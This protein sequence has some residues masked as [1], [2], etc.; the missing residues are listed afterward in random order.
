[1]DV[2]LLAQHFFAAASTAQQRPG[3]VLPPPV[4]AE[5]GR[6]PWPGN[7]RQLRNEMQ[8]LCALAGS[9]EI[10]VR[11]LSPVE[12]LPAAAS[13]PS[14]DLLALERWAI[15]RALAATG[16]NKAQAARLLGIGRRTLYARLSALG[17]DPAAGG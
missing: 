2:P 3:T 16:G 12:L 9:G 14:L 13:P 17:Q 5:L 1:G 6:R 11:A 7:V 10:E 4:L 8:R 15:E